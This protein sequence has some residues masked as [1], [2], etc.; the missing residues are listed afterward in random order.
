MEAVVVILGILL[1]LAVMGL[2]Y[3]NDLRKHWQRMYELTKK[4]RDTAWSYYDQRSK[5]FFNTLKRNQELI[6]EARDA[7]LDSINARR[8]ANLLH[9]EMQ[10]LKTRLAEAEDKQKATEDA[11]HKQF[12]AI[13]KTRMANNDITPTELSRRINAEPSYVRAILR[14][15]I[16]PSKERL[17]PLMYEA[18][19]KAE[20]IEHFN[21][22]YL[23]TL[24]KQR[25]RRKE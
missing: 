12:V 10:E 21:N 23:P 4:S 6:T 16:K 2:F 24:Q 7:K 13:L 15:R 19:F 9:V 25:R 5:D 1:F 17:Q 20:E 8:D 18:K 11:V 3:L 22:K 14:G